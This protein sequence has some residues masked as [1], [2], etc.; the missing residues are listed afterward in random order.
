[1]IMDSNN[2][3]IKPVV[4]E[5]STD[6]MEMGQYVF[7]VSMK[8][9]KHQIKRAIKDIFNVE[10]ERVNIIRVR[11]KRKRVRSQYGITPAWKKAIVKLK[12]GEKITLFE[13]QK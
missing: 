2:V 4:S 1:M 13:S 7:R 3:I 6:L 5:K 9:N 10:P 12:K 11:G 8:A